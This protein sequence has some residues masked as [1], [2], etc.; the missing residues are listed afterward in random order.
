M[1]RA[2]RR[3]SSDPASGGRKSP[4]SD[5]IRGLTPPARQERGGVQ[6]PDE[7]A[8]CRRPGLAWS[9]MTVDKAAKFRPP[10]VSFDFLPEGREHLHVLLAWKGQL[11]AWRGRVP[12]GQGGAIKW[13]GA[14][15]VVDKETKGLALPAGLEGEDGSPESRPPRRFFS[16]RSRCI[17]ASLHGNACNAVQCGLAGPGATLQR[18]NGSTAADGRLPRHDRW[19]RRTAPQSVLPGDFPPPLA[20]SRIEPPS[21]RAGPMSDS[22]VAQAQWRRWSHGR[23]RTPRGSHCRAYR[24]RHP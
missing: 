11:W 3:V 22:P 6:T 4:V 10:A 18:C 12:L 20:P 23:D 15:K 9:Q 1:R 2:C 19:S 16:R 13:H 17:V 5:L 8:S 7:V 21:R 24:R 14:V